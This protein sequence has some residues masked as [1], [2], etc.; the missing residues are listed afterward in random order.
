MLLHTIVGFGRKLRKM[1]I[2]ITRED[3]AFTGFIPKGDLPRRTTAA[4]GLGHRARREG[5]C[6]AASTAF[7]SSAVSCR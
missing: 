1:G 5:G 6:Y 3:L 2:E 7:M 4:A